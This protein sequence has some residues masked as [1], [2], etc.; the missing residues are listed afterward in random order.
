MSVKTKAVKS[1]ILIK[2][3][4]CCWNKARL[5]PFLDHHPT[6]QERDTPGLKRREQASPWLSSST[7]TSPVWA[8][9]EYKETNELVTEL[10]ELKCGD[11]WGELWNLRF[12]SSSWGVR[13]ESWR[14]FGHFERPASPPWRRYQQQRPYRAPSW[15]EI[16]LWLLFRWPLSLRTPDV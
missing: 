14:S 12:A 3:K 13:R 2:Q 9:A 7:S 10:T 5:L 1:M 11:W 16:L 15:A 8:R 4:Y 6:E